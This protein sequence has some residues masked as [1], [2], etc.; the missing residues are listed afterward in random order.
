MQDAGNPLIERCGSSHTAAADRAGT[1]GTGGTRW[2][3]NPSRTPT[4]MRAVF[5]GQ[6]CAL[7]ALFRESL[8]IL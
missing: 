3:S 7:C 8:T 1:W 2:K 6:L 4:S 5:S